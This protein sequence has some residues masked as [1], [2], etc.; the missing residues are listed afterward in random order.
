M[1]RDGWFRREIRQGGGGEIVGILCG[2]TLA[3]SP[4]LL[5]SFSQK[6]IFHLEALCDNFEAVLIRQAFEIQF[7][8]GVWRQ[9]L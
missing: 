7:Q 4:G 8:E 1:Q 5:F 9:C 6:D 2:E 3:H